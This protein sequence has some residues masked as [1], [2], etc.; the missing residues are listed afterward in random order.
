MALSQPWAGVGRR[1]RTEEQQGKGRG[2]KELA[3]DG[4]PLQDESESRELPPH[5]CTTPCTVT[6]LL[7]V[8]TP[9]FRR[10]EL[11]SVSHSWQGP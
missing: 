9:S 3:E 1:P 6:F 4:G 2:G 7:P 8:L 5:D 11:W 10:T